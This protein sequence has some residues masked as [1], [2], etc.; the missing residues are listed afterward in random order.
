MKKLIFI[1]LLIWG[2]I[3]PRGNLSI[4]STREVD[5]GAYYVKVADNYEGKSIQH[6]IIFFPTK[7][8]GN[9]IEEAVNDALWQTDGDLMTNCTI[10]Q[11]SWYIPYIYGEDILSIKGDIWKKSSNNIGDIDLE[12]LKENERLFVFDDGNLIPINSNISIISN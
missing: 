11:T 7:F 1:L 10:T 4:V 2:C 12:N 9:T 3:I 6:I 8:Y 5:M